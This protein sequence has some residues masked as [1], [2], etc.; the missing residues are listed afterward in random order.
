MRPSS[1]D[2]ILEHLEVTT[3]SRTQTC[4][5][6]RLKPTLLR[7]HYSLGALPSAPSPR[8]SGAALAASDAPSRAPPDTGGVTGGA[9]ADFSTARTSLTLTPASSAIAVTVSPRSSMRFTAAAPS[10][11][12]SCRRRSPSARISITRPCSHSSTAARRP[13]S[14][15]NHAAS[16]TFSRSRC[17]RASFALA[18]ASRTFL[19]ASV[20]ELI[21]AMTAPYDAVNPR[22]YHHPQH[23]PVPIC[24]HPTFPSAPLHQYNP[25]HAHSPPTRDHR[26]QP[27]STSPRTTHLLLKAKIGESGRRF[28]RAC[29]TPPKSWITAAIHE[30]SRSLWAG[31]R[32]RM[33]DYVVSKSQACAIIAPG[34]SPGL[35]PAQR[36]TFSRTTGS[37]PQKMPGWNSAHA[38]PQRRLTP[39]N[40]LR[41][42]TGPS[43]SCCVECV[44][45]RCGRAARLR[46]I[47]QQ[48]L[49]VGV[50]NV[51]P[52]PVQVQLADDGVPHMDHAWPVADV[53]LGPFVAEII[54]AH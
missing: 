54:T 49:A 5:S 24:P 13:S 36:T 32:G 16:S 15:R 6:S 45:R 48:V 39:V 38:K 42:G 51:E 53:G 29:D 1:E 18:C 10:W 41:I 8:L 34:M 50:G 28:C 37:P 44:E 22:L 43:D 12:C 3:A 40:A 27:F 33:A 35:S 25:T 31:R 26:H 19:R 14:T 9:P 7:P 20:F 23:R 2:G 4:G 47:G 52:V 11:R 17:N 30:I 46:A 21:F